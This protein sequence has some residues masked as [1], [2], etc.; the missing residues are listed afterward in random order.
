M[1]TYN[2]YLICKKKNAKQNKMSVKLI[3]S[4]QVVGMDWKLHRY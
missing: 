1:I 2:K 4:N 3:K